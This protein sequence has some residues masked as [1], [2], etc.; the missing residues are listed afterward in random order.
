LAPLPL[1]LFPS[2]GPAPA[3]LDQG[4]TSYLNRGNEVLGNAKPRTKDHPMRELF[5]QC[6][7]AVQYGMEAEGLAGRV[8]QPVMVAHDLLRMHR[9]TFAT[10]WKWPTFSRQQYGTQ[11]HIDQSSPSVFAET[12]AIAPAEPTDSL[13]AS[14]ILKPLNEMV[15]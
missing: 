5:R 15:D 3:K 6:V 9:E 12:N 4:L 10:F 1:W 14:S 7:L 8:G 13:R 2:M 11:Q